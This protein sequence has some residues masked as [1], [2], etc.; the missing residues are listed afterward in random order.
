MHY[1]TYDAPYT[2]EKRILFATRAYGKAQTEKA[3]AIKENAWCEK[4]L[5]WLDRK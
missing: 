4:K 5:V 2:L 3:M 1:F